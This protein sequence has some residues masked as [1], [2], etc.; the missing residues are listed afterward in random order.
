M[1]KVGS[2]VR[3]K[4]NVVAGRK[5]GG[6]VLER[7]S[8]FDGILT[9]EWLNTIDGLVKLSNGRYYTKNMLNCI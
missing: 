3:L 7:T 4:H 6:L 5:Y 2:R 8:V 9:V 1:L